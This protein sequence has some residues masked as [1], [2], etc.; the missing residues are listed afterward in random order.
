M[1]LRPFSYKAAWLI[2]MPQ[3]IV[4]DITRLV[5]RMFSETPNGI[6]RVD[7]AFASYFLSRSEVNTGCLMSFLGPR[8]F[9]RAAARDAVDGIAKHW[10][11]TDDPDGDIAYRQ[12]VARLLDKPDA[13][14]NG[15]ITRSRTGQTAGTMHW[16]RQ[17]GMPNGTSLIRTVPTGAIYI[18]ASQF[19]LWVPAYFSWLKKRP[20]IKAV[21]FVHDLLPI[22]HPEFFRPAEYARHIKRLATVAALGA[23]IITS[24]E[25]VQT[26]LKRYMLQMGRSDIPILALPLPIAPIFFEPANID[27][28]LRDTTYFICCGTIEPRKNHL[29]LL[30]LWRKLEEI[31][32]AATPKLV[33]IGNRGWEN[34]NVI[35]LLE[36]SSASRSSIIE[37]SGLSTPALKRLMDTA[38][39]LLMPSFA[40]GYGLPLA[41]AL[42]AG[43]P[44]IASDIPVFREIGGDRVT[45]LSPIAGDRWLEAVAQLADQ[46]RAEKQSLDLCQTPSMSSESY[47]A[48]VSEFLA[49]ISTRL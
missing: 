45:R 46:P 2:H 24:S 10:G 35:D 28:R 20:D 17:H 11:E 25:I 38:R 16:L 40:E 1:F 19:P 42:V 5:T 47:F 37:V 18:N 13:A 21:F 30:H 14:S 4:Y 36:R 3:P 9:S 29:I 27:E 8:Q 44:V 22:E 32:G 23:A 49:N 7:H 6:D 39:A 43:I 15:R 26:S 31:Y 48:R 41:E 33:L 12:V 34:E